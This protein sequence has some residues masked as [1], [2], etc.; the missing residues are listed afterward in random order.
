MCFVLECITGF[1]DML[2]TLVLSQYMNTS[3]FISTFIIKIHEYWLFYF[4][5][6]SFQQLFEPNNVR[7][8]YHYC[9]IFFFCCRLSC[10]IFLL[11]CPRYQPFTKKESSTT[12]F[13]FVIKIFCSINISKYLYILVSSK[14]VP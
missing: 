2:I 11:A 1:F 13:F 7:E 8:I 4:N 3:S 10:A 9:H 5:L 14:F 12:S 6:H